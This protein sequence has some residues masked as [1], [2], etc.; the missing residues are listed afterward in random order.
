MKPS[1]PLPHAALRKLGVRLDGDIVTGCDAEGLVVRTTLHCGTMGTTKK[2]M[3]KCY[4]KTSDG[5]STMGSEVETLRKLCNVRRVARV[6]ESMR[7]D[8]Y[9]YMVT[10][11]VEG[12]DLFNVITEDGEGGIE[13]RRAVH[14]AR[15]IL[16][17][18][19]AV[20]A[21]GIAHGDIKPENIMISPNDEVTLVD[22]AYSTGAQKD[23]KYIMGTIAYMAPEQLYGAHA[24]FP[25]DMFAVGA[26]LFVMMTGELAFENRMRSNIRG[27]AAR[28]A[29]PFAPSN[30]GSVPVDA[31]LLIS[32]L[33]HPTPEVRPSAATALR[34]S[35]VRTKAVSTTDA[36]VGVD[37]ARDAG[38]WGERV[39][40]WCGFA[41]FR[42]FRR[43]IKYLQ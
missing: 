4:G 3:V 39:R 29:L 17:A 10:P 2:I 15:E 16:E 11:R 31:R 8:G 37:I 12:R 34:A 25:V 14:I 26:T 36:C 6:V 42:M 30:W 13:E 35:W 9:D 38:P 40:R 23:E 18:V 41:F 7:V 22:F 20:H 21:A 24:R 19:K 43:K 5:K 33:V 1:A 27:T 32:A 28:M